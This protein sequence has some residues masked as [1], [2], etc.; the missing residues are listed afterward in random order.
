MLEIMPISNWF[1][2]ILDDPINNLDDS[3][4]TKALVKLRQIYISSNDIS[5]F[6]EKKKGPNEKRNLLK[7]RLQGHKQ[8]NN[9][10]FSSFGAQ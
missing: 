5:C 9:M 4:D 7:N 2:N 10:F 6:K 1:K 3:S 8:C